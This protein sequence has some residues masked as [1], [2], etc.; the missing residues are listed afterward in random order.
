[1]NFYNQQLE[2]IHSLRELIKNQDVLKG[3]QNLLS[4]NSKT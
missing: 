1:M 2:T 4:E 3:A